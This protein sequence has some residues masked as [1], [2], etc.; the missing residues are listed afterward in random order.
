VAEIRQLQE[1][2]KISHEQLQE[3][4]WQAQLGELRDSGRFNEDWI[5]N[6]E[7]MKT[8]IKDFGSMMDM[9][10]LSERSGA[11]NILNKRDG[12]VWELLALQKE[13]AKKSGD[14]K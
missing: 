3:L 4:V 8:S 14:K 6:Y 1:E 7:N 2:L 10:N 5:K 11:R 13:K 9:M 12:L